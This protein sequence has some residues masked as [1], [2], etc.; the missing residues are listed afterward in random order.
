M[1]PVISF[2]GEEP[3]S[4]RGR[5]VDSLLHGVAA[6]LDHVPLALLKAAQLPT[7]SALIHQANLVEP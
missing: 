7:D 5:Q 2:D 4:D 1:V 3:R 6:T